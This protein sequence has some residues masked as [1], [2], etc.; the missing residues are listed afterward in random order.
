MAKCKDKFKQ[1][2]K[3]YYY[4]LLYSLNEFVKGKN[5]KFLQ[6]NLM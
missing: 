5:F 4:S 3:Q 1:K 6:K 2:M